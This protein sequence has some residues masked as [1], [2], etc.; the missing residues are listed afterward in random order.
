MH[1]CQCVCACVRASRPHNVCLSL[2][3]CRLQIWQDTLQVAQTHTHTCRRSCPPC[4]VLFI[5]WNVFEA[6]YFSPQID[7]LAQYCREKLAG[8]RLR[9]PDWLIGNNGKGKNIQAIGTVTVQRLDFHQS[10]KILIM[11]EASPD[12]PLNSAVT[13]YVDNIEVTLI[14]FGPTVSACG[15]HTQSTLLLSGLCWMKIKF[16]NSLFPLK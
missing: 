16:Y 6:A 2:S 12:N 11:A 15:V 3:E 5:C 10:G 7:S 4:A 14:V 1:K 8:L 9:F 13:C